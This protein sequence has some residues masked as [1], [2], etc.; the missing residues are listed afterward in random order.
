MP[1]CS[2]K[3]EINSNTKVYHTIIRGVDK[4][5]IFLDSQDYR[6]FLKEIEITEEK[7]NY[8]LY[9]YCLMSNHVHLVI[10]DEEE[11]ISKIM[12]NIAMSYASYYNKKYERVGHLFQDRFFSRN[13]ETQEYLLQLC[14]YIHRNPV[15]ARISKID[16]YEWSSYREYIEQAKLI[17]KTVILKILNPDLKEAM[18]E[19]KNFQNIEIKDENGREYLEYEISKKLTDTQVKECIEKKLGIKNIKEIIELDKLQRDESIYKLKDIEGTSKAQIARVLGINHK[20]V[21]RIM[22]K[23]CLIG[24]SPQRDK[25]GKNG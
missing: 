14:R 24:D 11:Q 4:Q 18:K 1:R 19:F 3:N 5:D 20:L 22:Q 10:Y 9:V 6:K 15:K 17:D 21:E 12:Q 2:R 13:V 25:G 7:Y 23:E 16:Q 8:K